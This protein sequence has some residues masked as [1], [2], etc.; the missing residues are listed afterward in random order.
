MKDVFA[1]HAN[2]WD[3]EQRISRSKEFSEIIKSFL[4]DEKYS[5]AMEFGA[6]TGLISFNMLDIFEKIV[7]VDVSEAMLA[8]ADEKI[9]LN[10]ISSVK[11]MNIDLS[12]NS[13]EEK[14]D[15][16]YTSLAMHHVEDYKCMIKVLKDHLKAGGMFIIIDLDDKNTLFHKN[17]DIDKEHSK[18]HFDG[19]NQ[20]IL[21]DYFDE[22]GFKNI[23][24][25]NKSVKSEVGEISLLC[26]SAVN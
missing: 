11:T 10:N 7:L 3:T 13:I 18:D 17:K 14:F 20:E 12:T 26:M 21:Y 6:G 1:K 19:F 4:H 2:K 24:G 25:E 23:V 5:S 9:K 15:V 16:I 8:V 22:I